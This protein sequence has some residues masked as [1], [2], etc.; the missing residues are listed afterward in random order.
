MDREFLPK[1][2]TKILNVPIGVV[3]HTDQ[4]FFKVKE[5]DGEK[6]M[7]S[8]AA[9]GENGEVKYKHVIYQSA[10]TQ[11]MVYENGEFIIENQLAISGDYVTCLKNGQLM[12][13]E[14]VE[15]TVDEEIVMRN[16]EI[17]VLRSNED[18]SFTLVNTDSGESDEQTEYV[19]RAVEQVDLNNF[20]LFLEAKFRKLGKEELF[21]QMLKEKKIPI[22]LK[23]IIDNTK[24]INFIMGINYGGFT[25]STGLVANFLV[26]FLRA[27]DSE[28]SKIMDTLAASRYYDKARRLEY[29]A[30][31]YEY[32]EKK[33]LL[34]E[35]LENLPGAAMKAADMWNRLLNSDDETEQQGVLHEHLDELGSDVRERILRVCKKFEERRYD[36]PE[37]VLSLKRYEVL[38]DKVPILPLDSK[39][40]NQYLMALMIEEEYAREA[41]PMIENCV[42]Q[43]QERV[44]NF[45]S[46]FFQNT[47]VKRPD[48][49]R[50]IS[51]EKGE[52]NYFFRANSG[53]EFFGG[54]PHVLFP[55]IDDSETIVAMLNHESTHKIFSTTNMIRRRF[56]PKECVP[57]TLLNRHEEI[58]VELIRQCYDTVRLE[59]GKAVF[60]LPKTNSGGSNYQDGLN[61]LLE[62]ARETEIGG[63]K[64]IENIIEGV[65]D[66][67]DGKIAN[68]LE[69]IM[70]SY[71]NITGKTDFW[72]RIRPYENGIVGNKRYDKKEVLVTIEDIPEELRGNFR[73]GV[74]WM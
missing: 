28:V 47:R 39:V 46:S 36:D 59:N 57:S 14:R 62:I 74:L 25:N 26:E 11:K 64:I 34:P 71:Q 5:E 63:E 43:S 53:S 1:E 70:E 30:K 20:T 51:Y 61:E 41:F 19:R 2:E 7:E 60:D 27:N 21:D 15:V 56:A 68:P 72:D 6:K 32:Y 10:P 9:I 52:V 22:N 44:D 48:W 29:G 17:L 18:G 12:S 13:Q 67:D 66:Y 8:V 69:Y 31:R 54:N 33:G 65:F 23:K 24:L 73:D 42:Q 50:S 16:G 35:G 55:E 45:W 40:F 49:F 4:G 58:L 38:R 3:V 37:L